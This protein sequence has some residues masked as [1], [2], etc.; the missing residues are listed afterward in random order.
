[1][2]DDTKEMILHTDWSQT[3][4]GGWIGQKDDNG[5]IKPIAFESR[6]LQPAEKNYSP[7]DGELLSLVHHLKH[8]RP[9]LLHRK[10]ILQT[11]QRAL[12]WLLEQKTLSRRQ[13]RWLDLI[14]EFDLTIQWLPGEHNTVAD[15]LSRRSHT[16]D[17]ETQTPTTLNN[18]SVKRQELNTKIQSA[19]KQ[20]QWFQHVIQ[21]LSGDDTETPSKIKSKLH[22]FS[23]NNNLLMYDTTR[24]CVPR[25]IVA[26]IIQEHHDTPFSAHRSWPLTYDLIAR[27]YYWPGMSEDIR[28]YVA[29]CDTC[30]RFK[31]SN[32]LPFGLLKPLEI[33]QGK[34]QSVGMDFIGPLPT[35]AAGFN[36]ITVF[37][38]RLTKMV[39]CR[40]SKTS[41]TAQDTARLYLDTIFRLHGL[42]A[43]IVS[44]RD[45]R[46]TSRFW[47]ELQR[48]LGTSLHMST[49][50][51]PATNGQTERANQTLEN[52]LR[53]FVDYHQSNWD[54]LLPLAE[55]SINNTKSNTT[56]L[57]PFFSN[58]GFHP[59][60]PTSPTNSNVPLA[61]ATIED[62]QAIDIFLKDRIRDAQDSQ[63]HHSNQRR[64]D[65]TFT[66]GDKVLLSSDNIIAASDRLRQSRKLLPKF[67]GPFTIIE[68]TSPVTFRLSLPPTLNI[69]DN[70]HVSLLKTWI[71]PTA[72]GASRK[73]P[74]TPPPILVDGIEEY[75]VEKILDV[76]KLRGKTH[77]LVKWKGFHDHDN[78]WEPKENLGHAKALVSQFLKSSEMISNDSGKKLRHFGGVAKTSEKTR[79]KLDRGM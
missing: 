26:D 19:M 66:V 9:Y 22:W 37:I 12:Q 40:P 34:W 51:H 6:K 35:T 52:I 79:C 67:L 8:F 64:R 68:Q 29:S 42:P 31:G 5:N 47:Q 45:T 74:P 59:R 27:N 50:F 72:V 14:Q 7:Y 1:M 56:G 28:K 18:I 53:M 16:R 41:D 36:S 24:T 75:E 3:A 70:F 17:A 61:Q 57:S 20:D 4:I 73:S 55:F 60:T 25:S 58:Y 33:H 65:H 39:H 44:D 76:K 13:Y 2:P 62:I 21:A 49:A 30:Q 23:M 71:E 78:T 11:D 15:A 43:S 54:T 32:N 38:D 63:S 46:F 48:L 10:V 69:H 77:Y